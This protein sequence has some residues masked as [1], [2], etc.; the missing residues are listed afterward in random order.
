[1]TNLCWRQ[2]V[3]T[4]GSLFLRGAWDVGTTVTSS[5]WLRLQR[6]F[7]FYIF[8]ITRNFHPLH[9]VEMNYLSAVQCCFWNT[10]LSWW[11]SIIISRIIKRQALITDTFLY[12]AQWLWWYNLHSICYIWREYNFGF[13]HCA[14]AFCCVQMRELFYM[15]PGHDVELHPHWVKLYQ[16]GSVGSGL[17]LA[18]ALL[19]IIS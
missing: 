8:H 9:L 18:K 7:L 6:M 16:M 17:V 11:Q 5:I 14:V 2:C 10:I 13:V 15:C 3:N 4:F 12:A 1:M 19:V